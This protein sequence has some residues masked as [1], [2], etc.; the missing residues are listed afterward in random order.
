MLL[1]LSQDLSTN[2]EIVQKWPNE[3]LRT[4]D[5]HRNALFFILKLEGDYQKSFAG[6]TLAYN[7]IRI[8]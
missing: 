5:R 4:I 8:I 3:S 6:W 7:N 2:D 1:G